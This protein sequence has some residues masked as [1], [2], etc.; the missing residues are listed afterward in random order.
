MNHAQKD[1]AVLRFLLAQEGWIFPGNPE[2]GR[3]HA[4]SGARAPRKSCRPTARELIAN[5]P[6]YKA[7]L[8][9]LDHFVAAKLPAR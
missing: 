6:G 3:L 2:G 5:E 8:M 7:L 9:T 1:T 4:G